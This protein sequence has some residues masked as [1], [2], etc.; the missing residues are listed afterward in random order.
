MKVKTIS[1]NNS[2]KNGLRDGVPIALG[3]IPVSFAFGVMAVKGDIPVLLAVL[4]SMTNLTSA[5]QLAGL[6]LILSHGS[7]IEA[8]LTQFV[9]NLRYSLMSV[10]V[11]QKLHESVTLPHR[12]A[13]SFGITDEIFAVAS[14][15]STDVGS[16]YMY[17]LITLPYFGWAGGTLLG[18]AAGSFL[19][20]IVLGALGIAIYGMFIAIFIPP[21]KKCF[22]VAVV[23]ALASVL[24]CGFYY[25]PF[26]KSVSSGFVIIICAVAAALVGAIIKPIQDEEE[27]AA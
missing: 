27:V 2:F 12:F 17:G 7:L 25:L 21:L 24:S 26:L 8:A 18:S 1:Y 19:P 23:V 20:A 10:S 11:S 9:I 13:V 22:A 4:I 15:Q 16:R 3:Y 14:G 6:S 5:G